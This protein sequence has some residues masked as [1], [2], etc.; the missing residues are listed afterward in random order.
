MLNI[1]E[2]GELFGESRSSMDARERRAPRRWSVRYLLRIH[3]D[4]PHTPYKDQSGLDLGNAVALCDRLRWTSSTI[5]DTLFSPFRHGSQSGCYY[6]Q[7]ITANQRNAT[8][9]FQ[10]HSRI[11]ETW[12]APAARRST[13]QLALWRSAGII[14]TGRS[15]IVI[16]N[17][18]AL[19]ALIGLRLARSSQR[20]AP[21]NG[22]RTGFTQGCPHQRAFRPPRDRQNRYPLS[23]YWKR[24][25][26][27]GICVEY[28]EPDQN[29]L[30]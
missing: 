1:L 2:S 30:Y 6:W 5:E 15:A 12:S 11:S 28:T 26:H 22:R 10:Y 7:S 25:G 16:R 23:Y 21:T 24:A 17:S 20:E 29:T 19:R 13:N 18:Q 9:V 4:Q 14:D 27:R 3:R 8:S